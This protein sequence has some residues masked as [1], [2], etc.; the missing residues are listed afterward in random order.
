MP[1]IASNNKQKN[2]KFKG[3]SKHAKQAH[4][5]PKTKAKTKTKT[6]GIA[7]IKTTKISKLQRLKEHKSKK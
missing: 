3:T 5:K 4:I 7:K 1:R 2:K 6:K